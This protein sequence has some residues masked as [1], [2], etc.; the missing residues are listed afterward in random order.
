MK[1]YYTEDED[2]SLSKENFISY[3]FEKICLLTRQFGYNIPNK[4]AKNTENC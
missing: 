3:G 1:V 2:K 4:I